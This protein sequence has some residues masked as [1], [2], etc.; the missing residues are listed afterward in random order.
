MS[1]LR[2]FGAVGI[3]GALSLAV[4]PALSWAAVDTQGMTLDATVSPRADLSSIRDANSVVRGT[5]TNVLFD[6]YDDVDM[7]GGSGAFMYAP[8]RSEVGKNWNL[9]RIDENGASMTLTA[10]VGGTIG[11]VAAS[12]IMDVFF[13][14]FFADTGGPG[15]QASTV[16]ENLDSFSR[17]IPSTFDGIGSFNYRLTVAGLPSGSYTTATITFT[18][19]TT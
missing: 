10:D 2:R 9:L 4:S 13:G 5:A 6:K 17:T 15:T 8:Y 1:L 7:P 3:A 18:L 11:G 14:G 12:T 16:W 19:T